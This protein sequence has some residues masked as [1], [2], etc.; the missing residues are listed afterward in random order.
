[1]AA[2]I[3]EGQPITSGTF[4]S[5]LADLLDGSASVEDDDEPADVEQELPSFSQLMASRYP[6]TVVLE[7]E[8][9]ITDMP[10]PGEFHDSKE[11]LVEMYLESHGIRTELPKTLDSLPIPDL[12]PEGASIVQE[13]AA[14]M[15]VPND[16]LQAVHVNGGLM[17]EPLPRP[18]PF[19]FP[20]ATTP[21]RAF[22]AGMPVPND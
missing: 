10:L 20:T 21:A 16:T 5:S 13:F 2:A 17:Q 3:D 22:A 18:R 6:V 11:A 14:G 9:S 19:A 8:P 12:F 7:R 15:P 1:V 4:L